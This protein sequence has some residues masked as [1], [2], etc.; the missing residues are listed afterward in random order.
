[1]G[2]GDAVI[3][4]VKAYVVEAPTISQALIKMARVLREIEDDVAMIALRVDDKSDVVGYMRLT[5]VCETHEDVRKAL[6]ARGQ[7]QIC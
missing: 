7:V 6:E 1:M 5:A 2:K 4:E 3:K